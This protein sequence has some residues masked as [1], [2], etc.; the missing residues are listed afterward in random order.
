MGA[1]TNSANEIFGVTDNPPPH[2]NTGDTGA[3]ILG[4][5]QTLRDKLKREHLGGVYDRWRRNP[6]RGA[7]WGA[8][9]Y[10]DGDEE[11]DLPK[12]EPINFGAWWDMR[13][14]LANMATIGSKL[15]DAF[16]GAK[17]GISAVWK[18][19]A[20]DAA[21][22]K[23]DQVVGGA[24]QYEDSNALLSGAIDGLWHNVRDSLLEL[25][26]FGDAGQRGGTYNTGSAAGSEQGLHEQLD[27]LD[28]I[29]AMHPKME[30]VII[31]CIEEDALTFF[32]SV[33]SFP[34]GMQNLQA[35]QVFI[36]V[37][38][39][40]CGEYD[41]VV[42]E[43]RA[44][45]KTA[46]DAI[47]RDFDQFATTVSGIDT[48]AKVGEP[49]ATN[50]F[51]EVAPPPQAQQPPPD[52]GGGEK[53]D[54]AG[55]KDAGKHDGG[56][57]Q[58][59]D[60]GGGGGGG[61]GGNQGGGGGGSQPVA[62]KVP[63]PPDTTGIFEPPGAPEDPAA[64]TTD[65]SGLTDPGGLTGPGADQVPGLG[66]PGAAQPSTVTITDGDRQITVSSPDSRGQVEVTIDDGSG[67]PKHYTLSFA[68]QQ[69]TGAGAAGP[70][71]P[72]APGLPGAAGQ[73]GSLPQQAFGP[74]GGQVP[75][76]P[77][78]FVQAGAD[79]VAHFQDGGLAVSAVR[80]GD[81]VALTL[82]D[83]SGKPTTYAV[84]LQGQA[85]DPQQAAGQVPGGHG[86]PEQPTAQQ[87]GAPVHSGAA[88]SA[89]PVSFAQPQAVPAQPDQAFAQPA[90]ADW[91]S[92]HASSAFTSTDDQWGSAG[93]GLFADQDPGSG[94]P[95][96]D[97]GTDQG[98]QAAGAGE[99]GLASASPQGDQPGQQAG[100]ALGGGGVM[101]GGGMGGGGGG[102]GQGGDSE[103][104]ASPWRTIG[105]L[106]DADDEW[107]A[108]PIGGEV[109]R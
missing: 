4:R 41:D 74:D 33:D 34:E 66:Q 58:A 46:V 50:P 107:P 71:T 29:A 24:K 93:S 70:G 57:A 47:K 7:N 94:A 11:K 18:G 95:H 17:T 63:E 69:T 98:M 22:A 96:D 15:T 42:T 6:L 65:P 100:S 35:I 55:K 12:L 36:E 51:A 72:G 87:Q 90:T 26:A 61:G 85:A 109:R 78:Q 104:Q 83:G 92:T 76:Q 67:Q 8:W 27:K 99:A 44:R 13:G 37:F 68:D 38:N 21:M 49:T 39:K 30:D 28:R 14:R 59:V 105:N 48:I 31:K 75:G 32:G 19:E 43:W 64:G 45:I 89:Q 91:G 86:R 106:F 2:V 77:G 84:D 81:G 20:A 62:A 108:G 10:G 3:S 1:V 88:P 97:G 56:G 5:V 25:A 102:G 60:T 53:K 101:G 82:D 73:P 54:D 40:L 52:D 103:R 16:T 80:E 9:V 23:F 79:G